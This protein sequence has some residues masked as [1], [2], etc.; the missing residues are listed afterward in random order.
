MIEEEMQINP[1]AKKVKPTLFK[2]KDVNFIQQTVD[3]KTCKYFVDHSGNIFFIHD[4]YNDPENYIYPVDMSVVGKRE[5]NDHDH[6]HICSD[7]YKVKDTYNMADE[8]LAVTSLEM[9]LDVSNGVGGIKLYKESAPRTV[10]VGNVRVIVDEDKIKINNIDKDF[11]LEDLYFFLNKMEEFEND[12][13][14]I[15]FDVESIVING[16]S[17]KTCDLVA[18]IK[19]L[20]AFYE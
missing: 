1:K 13:F 6:E 16:V 17:I 2:V 14:L 7:D 11:M 4:E 12:S 18:V 19:Q 5:W 3:R 20:E 15:P 10:E 8:F 9:A